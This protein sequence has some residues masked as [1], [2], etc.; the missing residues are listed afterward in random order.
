MLPQTLP[1][2]AEI[3][4]VFNDGTADQT[5]KAPIGGNGEV[6]PKGKT[7]TYKISTSSVD[8]EY[9]LDVTAPG[10][11]TY[12]GGTNTYSVK[13]YRKSSAGKI[14][15]VA[16]KAQFSEDGTTWSDTAPDWLTEFTAW[17]W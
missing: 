17:V 16:W 5:L 11:F 6:W 4:V 3:E 15:P 10:A 12:A 14:E 1:D 13:S 9:F 8:W 2:D 7:V